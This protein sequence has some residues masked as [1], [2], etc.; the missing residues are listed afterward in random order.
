MA[1]SVAAS[2]QAALSPE[3]KARVETRP[4]D[5][6]DAYLLY[7]RAREYH[8]RATGL[9]QDYKTAADLYAQAVTLDPGLLSPTPDSPRRWPI[10][11]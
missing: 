4:T 9:L 2:L 1:R 3:E 11:I 6:A 10:P 5:N 8:T 7:L